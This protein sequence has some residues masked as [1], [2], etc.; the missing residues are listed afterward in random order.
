[1]LETWSRGGGEPFVPGAVLSYDFTDSASKAYGLNMVRVG[2]KYCLWSG[3]VNNDGIIDFTDLVMVDNASN[4]FSSGYIPEDVNGDNFA[5]FSDL[6]LVDNASYNV[7][8]TIRPS[9]VG[10]IYPTPE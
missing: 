3:D 1:M 7:I 8:M 5:D 2:T 6:A 4:S 9:S 10:R